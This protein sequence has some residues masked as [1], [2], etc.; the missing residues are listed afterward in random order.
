MLLGALGA[1]L[2]GNN[3]AGK[4][5]NTAGEGIVRVG[6]GNKKVRKMDF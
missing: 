1:N 2:V 5:I 6:Y 3:L 4:Q